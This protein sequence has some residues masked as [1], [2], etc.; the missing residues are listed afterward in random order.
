MHLRR[1]QEKVIN[2]FPDIIKNYRKFILK[3]PTGAG[4]TVL[5][6]EIIKKFY[7]EKKIVVLCHRLVLLEQLERG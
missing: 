1:W 3:A 5:A 2:E 7:N 4:K 6:S